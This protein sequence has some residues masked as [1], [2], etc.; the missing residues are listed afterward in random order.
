LWPS[1]ESG[2]CQFLQELK[3]IRDLHPGGR[4][5][6]GDFNLTVDA[7]DKNNNNLN[8]RMMGKFRKLLAHLELKEL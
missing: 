8:L 5:V 2:Q 1:G 6:P 7:A 3:D 4:V